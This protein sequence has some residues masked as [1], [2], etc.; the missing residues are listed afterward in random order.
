M[1]KKRKKHPETIITTT[2][3]KEEIHM[4]SNA[5]IAS[6]K[7]DINKNLTDK[8]AMYAIFTIYS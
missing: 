2:T 1:T 6:L 4:Q 8:I 3:S 7:A 5:F